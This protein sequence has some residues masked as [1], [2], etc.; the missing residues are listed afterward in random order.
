MTLIGLF[1]ALIVLL[2]LGSFL[3]WATNRLI[4]A[5]HVADPWA[6][7][8]QVLVMGLLLLVGLSYLGLGPAFLRIPIR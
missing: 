3:W 2:L 6:T 1:I 4:A 5:F 8:F 7:L